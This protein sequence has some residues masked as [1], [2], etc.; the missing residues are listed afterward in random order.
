MNP[1]SRGDRAM[2]PET[3]A[4]LESVFARENAGLSELLGIDLGRYWPWMRRSG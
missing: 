3:R 2:R 1:P 4:F